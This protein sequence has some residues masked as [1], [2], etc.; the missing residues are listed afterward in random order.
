MNGVLARHTRVWPVSYARISM[1]HE[2]RDAIEHAALEV[3]R[4]NGWPLVVRRFDDDISDASIAVG[5]ALPPALGKQRIRLRLPRDAIAARAP[6]LTLDEAITVL[7]APWRDAL[8]PIA[9]D[10]AQAKIT[11]HV[12]GSVSWQAQTGLRY[13]HADSDIDLFAAPGNVGELGAA[14]ALFERAS[15]RSTVRIDGEVVFPG[16]DA[17][18]WREWNSAPANARVLAKS[19]ARAALVPRRALEHRLAAGSTAAA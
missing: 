19:I 6:P 14:M 4:A 12:F 2:T 5:L 3:W 10:A 7:E 13:L 17:V 18:A 15:I 8:T 16:G 1:L 9:R 11:L